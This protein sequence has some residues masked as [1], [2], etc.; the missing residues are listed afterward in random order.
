MGHSIFRP[1]AKVYG[2][3]DKYAT[4]ISPLPRPDAVVESDAIPPK[5]EQARPLDVKLAAGDR[6]A[7]AQDYQGARP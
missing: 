3:R 4:V 1:A 7:A 6:W 2:E 5:F